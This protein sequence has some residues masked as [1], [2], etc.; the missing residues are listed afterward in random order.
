M[1]YIYIVC[2]KHNKIYENDK[3]QCK[4]VDTDELKEIGSISRL[5]NM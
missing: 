2:F 3:T 4:T 5:Y 1:Q